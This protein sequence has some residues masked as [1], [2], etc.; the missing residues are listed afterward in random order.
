MNRQFRYFGLI[1]STCSALCALVWAAQ[2]V[3][4]QSGIVWPQPKVVKPGESG[5]PPGD[6]MVL[7]DGK[8][9]SQWEG[10]ESWIVANGVA[11]ATKESIKTKAAFGD[12]QLHVE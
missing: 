6:A 4:Y 3:E 2:V 11:T 7:F 5:S 1:T 12:C 8:D 9:L 10:G